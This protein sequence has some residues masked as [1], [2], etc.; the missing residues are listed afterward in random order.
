[1]NIV[2]T[3]SE[4]ELSF[5]KKIISADS[6]Y[7]Q[8]VDRILRKIPTSVIRLSDG[9]RGIME[10]SLT[11]RAEGFMNDQNWKKKYGLTDIDYSF[12]GREL[13]RVGMEADFVGLTISGLWLPSFNV[14]KLFPN[15]TENIIDN[16]FP[17]AWK[18]QDRVSGIISAAPVLVLHREQNTLVAGLIKKYGGDINGIVLD[19]WK[20][21]ARLLKEATEHRAR[22]ILVSG[23]ASGKV[24]AHNLS[25][26]SGKVVLDIGDAL[27]LWC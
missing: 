17:Y 8:V 2:K 24:F 11:G 7:A 14:H 1:M 21:H 22:T 19:S 10:A 12:L 5:C 18:N 4:V 25:R 26:R 16:F 13:L 3:L 6:L 20:D 27:P 9:E 15:R 23:G